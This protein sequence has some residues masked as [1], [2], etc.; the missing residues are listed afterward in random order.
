MYKY[1]KPDFANQFMNN[2][3]VSDKTDNNKEEQKMELTTYKRPLNRRAGD[4]AV[5]EQEMRNAR[6][7]KEAFDKSEFLAARGCHYSL[8]DYETQ[9]NNNVMVIGGAG[10][11]KS[12]TIVSPNIEKAVGSYLILDP[13]GAL[14]NKYAKYLEQ[15][16]Y[17]VGLI[18]FTNPSHSL[19]FNPLEEVNT[20][21]DIMKIT[22]VLI[23][24]ERT[25]E[26]RADPFWDQNARYLLNS[27]IGYLKETNIMP[28]TFQT[29]MQLLRE[30]E[31]PDEDTKNSALSAR[32]EN[33]KK[34]RG[35]SW[36][37]EQFEVVNC[38][39]EKTYDC[40]KLSMASKF[41]TIDVPEIR[42][43]TSSNDIDFKRIAQEKTAIFVTVSDT[44][45]SLDVLA[46]IFFTQ[47]MQKLCEYADNE[48]PD[49]RLPIP[50]R[51]ILDDFATSCRISD[52][53]R[54][55]STIRARSISVMLMLQSEAQIEKYYGIDAD[56][57]ISNCDTYIY[58]G[59]NDIKSARSV[60]E[61]CNKPLNT[62][63]N[64]PVGSC[65]VFRRGENP[66]FT[67][68]NKPS[69]RER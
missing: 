4:T 18:D 16:G 5:R 14:Y 63:L 52:F 61:R 22:E 43:M 51:F 46:N 54:M 26:S 67:S 32:F 66:V 3:N 59:G 47:A 21:Q 48:C 50:V 11:G 15:K 55:I 25:M 13:K 23:Y 64:M 9:L 49:R 28:C 29:V 34:V 30:G 17:N 35:T 53:P 36:A 12:R 2:G 62:I 68:V 19:H 60:S 27:I 57:I 44:D 45:R 41:A 20:P 38:A 24:D 39:P 10:T 1:Y 7:A 69:E 37:A 56:T 40:I 6:E 33:L 31:R 65:W 8:N 58:L 42:K